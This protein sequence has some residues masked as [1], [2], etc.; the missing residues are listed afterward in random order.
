MGA[1]W[2]LEGKQKTYLFT[3]SAPTKIKVMINGNRGFGL[4]QVLI[5]LAM[6]GILTMA[7]LEIVNTSIKGVKT[8]EMGDEINEF[9]SEIQSILADSVKCAAN[10]N[11]NFNGGNILTVTDFGGTGDIFTAPTAN[12]RTTKFTLQGM[13]LSVVGLATPPA[14]PTPPVLGG[15]GIVNFIVAITKDTAANRRVIVPSTVEKIIRL[16][17]T[18]NA[19][20]VVTD[21]HAT[22]QADTLIW[23]RA[24]IPSN[25]F[26]MDK[27]AI[28][29]DFTGAPTPLTVK[30]D[31]RNGGVTATGDI[32]SSG[33]GGGIIADGYL[34]VKGGAASC[35]SAADNGKIRYNS[36]LNRVQFCEN[37]AWVKFTK[38]IGQSCISYANRT[39][40]PCAATQHLK[41]MSNCMANSSTG[42]VRCNF[43]CCT[44]LVDWN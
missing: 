13:R 44:N 8:A 10:I 39:N 7:L 3:V 35:T 18:T 37:G 4:I 33:P 27:V 20:G 42:I 41:N 29:H 36:G 34:R 2:T 17:V 5:A 26:Y 16:K 25:I 24:V 6:M 31:V 19:T 38:Y 15:T 23:K 14:P 9:V 11:V 30:L 21:C 22:A 40:S 12:L 28:G 1:N 32:E 43:E